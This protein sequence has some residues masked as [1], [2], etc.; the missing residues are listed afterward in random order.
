MNKEPRVELL[1]SHERE[2]KEMSEK[3]VESVYEMFD[4]KRKTYEAIE[5]DNQDL[6][7]LQ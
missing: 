1:R 4:E 6:E 3:M 7:E 5:V 2:I